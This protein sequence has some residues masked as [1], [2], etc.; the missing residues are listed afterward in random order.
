MNQKNMLGELTAEANFNR[1]EEQVRRFWRRHEVPDAYRTAGSDGAPYS[2][3]QQPLS[4]AGQPQV[5]QVRLLATADLLARYRAMRGAAVRRRMGWTC[6]GLPIEVAVEKTLGPDATGYDLARFNAA[7]HSAAVVGIQRG[8][9]LA[10][11]LGV[12]AK[13][14]ESFVSLEPRAVGAVW[15]ALWRLWE[16]GQLRQERRVVSVCPRCA[17]PLSAAETSRRAIEGERRGVWVRLPWDGEPGVYFLAWTAVPWTLAGM[18]ALAAHP[19]AGYAVVEFPAGGGEGPPTRLVLAEAALPRTLPG[20]YRV[21]RRLGGRSLRGARYHAPFTFLPAGE[22][23][24]RVLLS[25][26]VPLDRGTGLQP[27]TPAFDALSLNLAAAHELPAP[28]LLDDW[29][30]FDDTVMPWRGLSPLDAEPLLVENLKTRGLVLDER[31]SDGLQALCPYCETALLPLARTVWLLETGSGPWIVGRDRAWGVPLPVWVCEQCAKET[32]VAGLDDLA[33]RAGL[34][35]DR[36]DPHRPA[37]DRLTFPC[38]SCQG[39]MRRV[40]PVVDAAFEAALLPWFLAAEP[41]AADLAVGLGDKDLGWL[42]D[43][44]ETEALLRGALAWKQSLALPESEA[45]PAWDLEPA[46]PADALRWATYA[47]T[48]PQEAE[49]EFLRPLW[50]LAMSFL[51]AGEEKKGR[52]GAGLGEC[53]DRWLAARLRQ[54]SDTV[55]RALDRHD[56]GAAAGELACLV[57]DLAGWYAPRRPGGGREALVPLCWLLA[58]FVPHLAEAIHRRAAGPAAES[59]HLSGWPGR[60]AVEGDR[61]SLVLMAL[62]RRVAALGR[63]ARAGVEIAPELPLR[64]GIVYPLGGER[65]GVSGE[66]GSLEGLLAEVLG[67]AQVQFAPDAADRVEWHLA[68]DP[69]RWGRRDLAPVRVDATLDG[70]GAKER[71]ELAA[72]LWE[73]LSVGIEVSGQAISVL[74]DQVRVSALAQPGWAAAAGAGWLVMLDV[75]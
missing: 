50:R 59:V 62:L 58:P 47:A 51:S 38:E 5:D 66:T 74:P 57:A 4:A 13:P 37:V 44:T 21:E 19:E 61:E 3:C 67:V 63:R 30:R 14:A 53:L 60:Q 23:I 69:A 35:A 17:T 1:I 32:C 54:A 45:G 11:R 68:V 8:E 33:R 65:E 6:H 18:V 12:W 20:A 26:Q 40:A 15:S 31:V 29:G 34:D 41:G 52:A 46:P 22:G 49:R 36:I 25:D 56:P 73:G 2:V 27:V 24:G 64:R 42:G 9:A 70:L 16:G 75:G 43:L 72:N 48:T 7:C 10:G 55:A 28:R 39:T 71:A